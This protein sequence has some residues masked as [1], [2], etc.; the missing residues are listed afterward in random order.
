MNEFQIDFEKLEISDHDFDRDGGFDVYSA[1]LEYGSVG[2][3]EET[4]RFQYEV[5]KRAG[6]DDDLH[7]VGIEV[8]SFEKFQELRKDEDVQLK[9]SLSYSL[10]GEDNEGL[11]AQAHYSTNDTPF[12]DVPINADEQKSL[13]AFYDKVLSEDKA[14]LK[15]EYETD[16]SEI[17]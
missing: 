6:V 9:I 2:N 8:D 14:N 12:S 3:Q 4:D 7:D 15:A 11:V 10:Y 17:E 5:M 16:K 1:T 13:D